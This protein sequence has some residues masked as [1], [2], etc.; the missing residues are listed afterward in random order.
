MAFKLRETFRNQMVRHVRQLF[1]RICT[2]DRNQVIGSTPLLIAPSLHPPSLQY[3][4]TPVLHHS[5]TSPLQYS[6]TPV[7]H[8]SNTP[9]LQHS[10]IPNKKG[11]RRLPFYNVLSNSSVIKNYVPH[12]R[13]T[14]WPRY[15]RPGGPVW[16][17]A[18]RQTGRKPAPGARSRWQRK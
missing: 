6:T 12:T 11:A 5:S 1:N 16:K 18:N 13:Y 10:I 3:S 9:P 4:I 8:H 14:P 17:T 2:W 7:L 15:G